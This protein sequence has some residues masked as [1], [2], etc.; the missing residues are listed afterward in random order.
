MYTSLA[1]FNNG[2][3]KEMPKK[4]TIWPKA[5][6]F[7]AKSCRYA[8]C[9]ASHVYCVFVKCVTKHKHTVHTRAST[10]HPIGTYRIHQKSRQKQRHFAAMFHP[11]HKT[12]AWLVLNTRAY[13]IR[14]RNACMCHGYLS[15][16]TADTQALV[17]PF[18]HKPPHREIFWT[19]CTSFPYECGNCFPTESHIT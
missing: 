19:C 10:P 4:K 12:P 6:I 3:S 2:P 8:W 18:L 11:T 5:N 16:C 13:I 14:A 9:E 15:E 1:T 7:F 17:P